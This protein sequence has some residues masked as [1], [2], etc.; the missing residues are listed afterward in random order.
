MKR[1]LVL[2]KRTVGSI[3]ENKKKARDKQSNELRAPRA[4]LPSVEALASMQDWATIEEKRVLAQALANDQQITIIDTLT[5]VE[6]NQEEY[7]GSDGDVDGVESEAGVLHPL[8]LYA[9]GITQ[10]N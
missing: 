6:N 4:R 7:F 9:R 3:V 8:S 10:T 1:D 5:A 2:K